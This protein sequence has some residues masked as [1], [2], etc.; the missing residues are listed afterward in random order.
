[1]RKKRGKNG[2]CGKTAGVNK[3]GKNG[4]LAGDH[5]ISDAVW[6][7]NPEDY[8]PAAAAD[9]DSDVHVHD[10]DDDDRFEANGVDDIV[11]DVAG[12]L[13]TAVWSGAMRRRSWS[14]LSWGAHIFCFLVSVFCF[15]VSVFKGNATA[16]LSLLS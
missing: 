16:F 15:L 9:D 13:R 6:S 12:W 14:L 5:D 11:V 4:K 3:N 7:K 1:M 8:H 10:D 2:K